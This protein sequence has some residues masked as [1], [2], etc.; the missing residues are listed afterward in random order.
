MKM[1]EEESKMN[2]HQ[3]EMGKMHPEHQHD[4]HHEEMSGMDHMSHMGNLKQKFIVSLFLA[5]PIIILSPMMGIHLPFQFTFKG[6]DWVVLILATILFIYGGRPFLSGAK[7]ELQ[8]K[9]PAMMTLIALGISVSYVYSLYAFWSNHFSQSNQHVMDFFWELATLIV[10]ML[11]G[12]WIEM[13]AVSNAGDA[14][15]KMAELLPNKA[16]KITDNGDIQEV[17]LQQVKVADKLLVQAGEKIPADGVVVEGQSQVN[18]SMVTG[19]AKE[20]KKAIDDQVI[21]GSVNGNGTLTIKVTGTGESGYL[22]QVMQLVGSAKEE[23]SKVENVSDKVAKWLF[24]IALTAGILA[25]IVWFSITREINTPLE[26]MV[27]VLVIAC[28]HALGLAIPLV[29]A[30]STSIGAKNGLLI[31]N[32]NALEA[33]KKVDVLLMDK[34]GTLTEGNFSVREIRS[35]HQDYTEQEILAYLASLE[36][37][38]NHPLATGIINYAKEQQMTIPTA[39]NTETIAGVGIKGQVNHQEMSVVTANYLTKMGL[40]YDEAEFTRLAE[41]GNSISYLLIN[42]KVAGIVAQGDQ[43]KA[44]SQSMIDA[45]KK[46]GIVPVMLTG[47]NQASAEVVA[48]Q[49]GIQEVYASLLPEDK[50]KIVKRYRDAG[51]VVMM[52]G[53]GVNDAPSLARANVGIAIGAGTDIA[54]D[55]ADVILVK[56]NPSDI[57]HFLS[58][59]KQTTKKMIQNLWWGAGYNLFA[60]P[61]AAGILA[62]FGLLLS[63]AVGAILMSFSTV[64]VAL[65]ALTLKIDE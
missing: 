18:E 58:L 49:L 28:P 46:Q 53:D 39:K 50:E 5:I 4:M 3:M 34:T 8:M 9:S 33:A 36:Q 23:K 32:R 41:A 11:L 19:E 63:P 51:N 15:K 42:Q 30:R 31:R 13:R 21:G 37:Q 27:T 7:M 14:L 2:H 38:S 65:N 47:D 52:V 26:R 45:L 29:T 59:A 17:D 61:L 1:K 60:I 55:S 56:S 25:F 35:L 62:P 43:I 48:K 24:Y 22:A 10:I 57:L 6:S 54:I 16:K 44:G 12:H 40:S 20:I 64:I